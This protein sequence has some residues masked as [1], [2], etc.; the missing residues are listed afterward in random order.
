[1]GRAV[2][3]LVL[4]GRGK[5]DEEFMVSDGPVNPKTGEPF[6]PAVSAKGYASPWQDPARA[7]DILRTSG[8]IAEA[9]ESRSYG[10]G[11]TLEEKNLINERQTGVMDMREGAPG[12]ERETGEHRT[13]GGRTMRL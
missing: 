12:A 3:T 2:H 9:I 8:A 10:M 6:E 7:A 5:F 13:T 11:D 1:M 4:E